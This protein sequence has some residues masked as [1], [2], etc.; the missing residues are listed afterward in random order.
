MTFVCPLNVAICIGVQKFPFSKP[1]EFG[2]SVKGAN[3]FMTFACP[4]NAATWIGVNPLHSTLLGLGV[5]GARAS[6]TFES[7]IAAAQ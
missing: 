4:L 1:E 6:I 5:K 3:I 2:F 7:P